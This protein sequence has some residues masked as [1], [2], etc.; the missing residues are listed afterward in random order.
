MKNIL[1]HPALPLKV[2]MRS[3]MNPSATNILKTHRCAYHTCMNLYD[4]HNNNNNNNTN[5]RLPWIQ[6]TKDNFKQDPFLSRLIG[7]HS[8]QRHIQ[9]N[10]RQKE[11]VWNDLCVGAVQVVDTMVKC[12]GKCD[13]DNELKQFV[14]PTL[15]QHYRSA[16]ER[17]R[18][19]EKTLQ[20]EV[21]T[22]KDV[23]VTGVR[24]L[25][26]DVSRECVKE[27]FLFIVFN[28]DEIAS[29]SDSQ[30]L[31]AVNEWI[32]SQVPTARIQ[33]AVSF[34]TLEK[35]QEV[36]GTITNRADE[37]EV[38]R[39]YHKWVLESPFAPELEWE[40]EDVDDFLEEKYADRD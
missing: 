34:T 2:A 10:L 19:E 5:N 7:M 27:R 40:L 39:A 1:S 17:L 4:K 8:I 6:Q 38:V 18:S 32:L 20:L 36:M 35:Y 13:E 16:F 28:R 21:D 37:A 14:R 33:V 11:W 30:G 25:I 23:S 29:I 9:R 26:G 22:A 15:L 31:R 3:C 24:L 12:I